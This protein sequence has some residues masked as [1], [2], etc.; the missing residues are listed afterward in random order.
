MKTIKEVLDKKLTGL[1]F[2]NRVLIPF[3]C[4]IL[5]LNIENDLITDFSP[6]CKGVHISEN[7]DFMEIYFHDYKDLASV[8]TEFELIKMIVVEKGKDVFNKKN[9]LKI[10]LHTETKHKLRIEKL[11]EDQIFIE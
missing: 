4:H 10:A 11:R 8:Q 6:C 5:K 9:H 2:G 7:P 3:H 1:Y